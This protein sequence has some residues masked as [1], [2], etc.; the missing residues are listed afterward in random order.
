MS[1]RLGCGRDAAS[2]GYRFGWE[3]A[4]LFGTRSVRRQCNGRGSEVPRNSVS[5]I[6]RSPIRWS[7]DTPVVRVPTAVL[8]VPVRG[9]ALGL[10][11]R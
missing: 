1:C 6:G 9:S 3:G 8:S 2:R 10:P 4:T 5:K 11:H 7:R